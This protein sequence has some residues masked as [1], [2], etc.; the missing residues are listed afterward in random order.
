MKKRTYGQYCGLARALD[1]LGERWSLLIVRELLTGPKRY[2]DLLRHLPGIG[3]NLLARRLKFLDAQG[4][5]QRRRLPA[6]AST[7]AYV[8]TE[9]GRALEPALVELTRWGQ[10]DLGRPAADDAYGPHWS[11]LALKAALRPDRAAGVRV[12]CEFRVGHDDFQAHL[13]DGALTTGPGPASQPDFVLETDPDTYLAVVS[14]VLTTE[15]ALRQGLLEV[16]G[17]RKAWA[18]SGRVFDFP[19]LRAPD[20]DELKVID[21]T[22]RPEPRAR[23]LR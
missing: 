10:A 6:P 2:K 9:R 23:R 15:E 18:G 11:Q 5:L 17:D 1:V 7:D 20:E 8:L 13:D 21:L 22:G 4:V 3:T 12:A 16:R 14:G 19:L